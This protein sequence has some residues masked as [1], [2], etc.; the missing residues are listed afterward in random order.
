MKSTLAALGLGFA[1]AV[2]G[3]GLS[4]TPAA[5]QEN[6]NNAW[7][8]VCSTIP[9][10]EQQ[11]C[12]LQ[13]ELRTNQGQFLA[14]VTI[15]ETDGESR[16]SLLASVP[17]GMIIPQGV[18]MQID[19]A[20]PERIPYSICYPNACFAERAIDEAFIE[21]LKRGGKLALVTFNQAGKQVRFDMTLIGFTAAYEGDGIDPQALQQQQQ[22]LQR[23]LDRRAQEARDRLVAEQRRAVD[24]ATGN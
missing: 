12:F 1:Y 23:E 8:K 13:Q 21:R 19:G 17:T 2:A 11:Q 16:K 5:A 9:Q 22:A 10:T 20:E 14:S 6:Q 3:A 4:A 7:L 18:A 24:E 15:R